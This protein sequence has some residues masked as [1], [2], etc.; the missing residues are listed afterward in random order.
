MTR[1]EDK[2]IESQMKFNLNVEWNITLKREEKYSLWRGIE[3]REISYFECSY[4]IWVPMKT[5]LSAAWTQKLVKYPPMR[6]NETFFGE[7]N[8]IYIKN[9]CAYNE[10]LAKQWKT[11]RVTEK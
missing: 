8:C 11:R 1:L 6:A 4:S 10:L 9:F 3:R 5:I 2:Q 7:W